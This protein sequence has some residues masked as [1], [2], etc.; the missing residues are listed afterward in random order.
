MGAAIS[1][2]EPTRAGID[3]PAQRADR[4]APRRASLS[5]CVITLDE[6]ACLPRCLESVRGLAAQVVVVDSGSRDRTREVARAAGAEVT[7]RAMT[8]YATQKNEAFA[9]ARGDWVLG[10]DADEWLDDELRAELAAL[11]ARPPDQGPG[12]YRMRRR[13]LYLGRPLRGTHASRE[14]KLRLV[15]RG[16][17]RWVGAGDLEVHERLAVEGAVGTLRGRLLHEP[18]RD[19]AEHAEK[20]VRYAR[21]VPTAGRARSVFGVTLEPPL[22][23]LKELVLL[24]GWRDGMR[25]LVHASMTASYFFLRGA[26][27]LEARW[28]RSASREAGGGAPEGGGA[29]G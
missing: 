1:V 27:A 23:L 22:V 5:V 2:Q 9:R 10:L 4:P 21:A 12:G 29:A 18:F 25:G 24:G 17:G 26:F 19:L 11:L 28:R 14:W 13:A 15:R 6:E 8:G 7:M 16:E 3:E 20:C